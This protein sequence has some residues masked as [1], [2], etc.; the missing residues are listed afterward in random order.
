MKTMTSNAGKK[1]MY[2]D[3]NRGFNSLCE[4]SNTFTSQ[5]NKLLCQICHK[6]LSQNKGSLVNRHHE[7]NYKNFSRN[8]P[9]KSD[10]K[11]AS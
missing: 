6:L 3:E 7:T 11:K 5:E 9:P 1:R 2:K 8:Y 4:E 10:M